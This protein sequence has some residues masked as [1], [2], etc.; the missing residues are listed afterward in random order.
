MAE[1]VIWR[2]RIEPRRNS[3][4]RLSFRLSYVL[5]DGAGGGGSPLPKFRDLRGF[6]AD[7]EHFE[8]FSAFLVILM[9]LGDFDGFGAIW[10]D[11]EGRW[12]REWGTAFA[13]ILR[14]RRD[15][16]GSELDFEDFEA[17]LVDF[18]HLSSIL[19]IL[20]HFEIF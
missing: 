9:D 10:G 16:G 13:E 20:E 19:M 6:E 5:D 14:V 11:L 4:R 1:I 7:L 17:L 15:F 2:N 18:D 12:G 3:P 8:A